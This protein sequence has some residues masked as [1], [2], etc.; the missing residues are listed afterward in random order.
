M[1]RMRRTTPVLVLLALPA[2]HGEPAPRPS[3]TASSEVATPGTVAP[4]VEPEAASPAS[5]SPA[6]GPRVAPYEVHEWGL[7]DV[8][9]QGIEVAAGPGRPSEP[10]VPMPVRKPVLY[11]HRDGTEP[12]E[13][14]VT[15][16]LPHGR[17]LEHWPLGEATA[18]ELRWRGVR[19]GAE[20]CGPSRE[21]AP[22]RDRSP[23]RAMPRRVACRSEDGICELPELPR[24][25]SDDADCLDVGG[26]PARLLFYRGSATA[27]SLPLSL[28]AG[29]GLGVVVQ[30]ASPT[31][32]SVG[33]LMRIRRTSSSDVRIARA[34]APTAGATALLAKPEQRVDV[35]RER[36]LLAEALEARGLSPGEAR[37][38]VGAWSASLFEGE[39]PS[40]DAVVYVLPEAD[41]ASVAELGLT[42]APRAIRRVMMV[43]V[44]ATTAAR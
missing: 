32:S 15:V 34:E 24:Y 43:R 29:P 16:R 31:A 21:A 5:A 17:L 7:V 4:T 28:R 40:T 25:V 37:A 18:S 35:A 14:T 22:E 27:V 12:L 20:G 42:P 36:R 23:A 41:V 38:F 1:T 10:D 30:G 26:V 6:S 39:G 13:V 2:C 9:A 33:T 3:T 8:S 44:D 19:V 11:F